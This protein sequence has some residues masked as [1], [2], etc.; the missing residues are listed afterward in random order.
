MNT[1]TKFSACFSEMGYKGQKNLLDD[2][3]TN[4]EVFMIKQYVNLKQT[5]QQKDIHKTN[6]SLF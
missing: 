1:S 2:S 5:L 4:H 6:K 3:D